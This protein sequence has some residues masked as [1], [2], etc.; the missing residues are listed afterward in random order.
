MGN[1]FLLDVKAI[2]D[3]K[4][5]DKQL[6]EV[7]SKQTIK[8]N[9]DGVEE[10]VKEVKVLKNELG[11]IVKVT[12]T[13]DTITKTLQTNTEKLAKEQK[14]VQD[15]IERSN[16]EQQKFKENLRLALTQMEKM[17]IKSDD[18]FKKYNKGGD[19]AKSRTQKLNSEMKSLTAEMQKQLAVQGKLSKET[20]DGLKNRQKLISAE[21]QT[22]QQSNATKGGGIMETA[23]K[24]LKFGAITSAIG[25]ATSVT[26]SMVSEVFK[27]DD[28]FTELNKV[29]DLTNEELKQFKETAFLIGEEVGRTGEEVVRATATF[30]RMGYEL[31]DAMNL[32]KE[33]LIMSNIADGLENVEDASQNLVGILKGFGLEAENTRAVLDVLNHTS[34]NNAVSFA[35]LADVMTRS[36]AAMSSANTDLID[37]ASLATAAL[38]VLGPDRSESV[39]KALSTMSIRIQANSKDFEEM[40]GIMT[41]ANGSFKSMYDILHELSYSWA[42]MTDE[43]RMNIVETIAG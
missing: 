11:E 15:N 38:E 6:K 24:V 1:N 41:S 5:I 12:K 10:V 35:S 3:T 17:S 33:A 28:A 26:S 21:L 20:I 29:T 36:G 40:T 37:T 43:Q 23:G 16:K 2:I 22:M 30:S 31:K 18:V 14:K 34:N 19:E 32:S 7:S 8:I 39:A 25:L 27:L 9:A 4:N 42:D 13:Q